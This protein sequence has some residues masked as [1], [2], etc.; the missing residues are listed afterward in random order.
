MTFVTG[1]SRE[2]IAQRVAVVIVNATEHRAQRGCP[3]P[4]FGVCGRQGEARV[5]A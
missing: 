4:G 2:W 1:K 3:L 5:F